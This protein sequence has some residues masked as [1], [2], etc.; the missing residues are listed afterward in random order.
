[1][2][3]AAGSALLDQSPDCVIL[4]LMLPDG[5]GEA[6]LRTIRAERRPIRVVVASAVSDENRLE[7]VEQ[8]EPD[9]IL[10]KPI[11]MGELLE[12]LGPPRR[13]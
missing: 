13:T 9:A 12:R 2:T 3:L 11:R 1:M 6:I 5:E 10:T 7:A 4:D 8:L